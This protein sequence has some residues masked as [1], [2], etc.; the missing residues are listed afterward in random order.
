[1][2]SKRCFSSNNAKIINKTNTKEQEKRESLNKTNKKEKIQKNN[3]QRSCLKCKPIKNKSKNNP[4]ASYDKIMRTMQLKKVRILDE[5][6]KMEDKK[7]TNRQEE[8]KFKYQISVLKAEILNE[9]ENKKKLSSNLE[10][11]QNR[12]KLNNFHPENHKNIPKN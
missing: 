11:Y 7:L 9:Q 8:K 12:Y 4:S 10:K 5:L 6:Q 2:P 3:S 1:V